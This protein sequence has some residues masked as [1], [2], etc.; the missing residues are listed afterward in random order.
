[1]GQKDSTQSVL[2]DPNYQGPV[3]MVKLDSPVG[4]PWTE[5]VVKVRKFRQH[6]I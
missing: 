3:C 6:N 4:R 2:E 5:Y 1:M